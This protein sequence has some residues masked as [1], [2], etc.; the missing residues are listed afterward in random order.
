MVGMCSKW[1]TVFLGVVGAGYIE[2]KELHLL[3]VYGE[4]QVEVMPDIAYVQVGVTTVGEEVE[5]AAAENARAVEGVLS[6]VEASGVG[7]ADVATSNFS[8]GLD[9][10]YRNKKGRTAYR[11][12]NTVNITVRDLSKVGQVLGAAMQ[13]GANEVR[14]LHMELAQ[15]REALIQARA[16]AA[17][18]ARQKAEH[19]ASLHG[20]EIGSVLEISEERGGGQAPLF[21]AMAMEARSVPISVGSQRLSAQIRVV[22]QLR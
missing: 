10:A 22:Y 13:G 5:Q 19:L 21:K 16:L 17:E 1:I 14:G 7:R 20:V 9:Q 8:I 15:P 3:E 4:G 18:D 11:V 6:A 2:A 12:N